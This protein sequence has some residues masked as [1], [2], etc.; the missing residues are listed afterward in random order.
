M[1][2]INWLKTLYSYLPGGP[3]A[4]RYTNNQGN[5]V[6]DSNL[7]DVNSAFYGPFL[8]GT[9]PNYNPIGNTISNLSAKVKNPPIGLA[10]GKMYISGATS[11]PYNNATPGV[12]DSSSQSL[13]G[14]DSGSGS[15]SGTDY[16][17]N[18]VEYPT[19][20]GFYYDLNNPQEK[21]SFYDRRLTDL[22]Y[23]RDEQIAA[24]DQQIA[25]LVGSSKN[26]ATNYFKQLENLGATKSSGDTS[27]IDAFTAASPNAFQS[28]EA[29]SY[30]MANKNYLKTVG[31]TAQQANEAVGAN[32]LANPNDVGQLDT[33]SQYGRQLADY[34]KGRNAVGTQYNDY[35]SGIEQQNNPATNPFRFDYQ[36]QGLKAPAAVDLSGANKFVDFKSIPAT[37]MPGST[38]TPSGNVPMGMTLDSYLGKTKLNQQDTDF[39]RKYLLGQA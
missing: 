30:D 22:K 39:L 28:S 17:P 37:A 27:R 8:P 26:Y 6:G 9:E 34:K 15:G 18:L 7:Y 35:L 25:D 14:G 29:N 19:G 32:Y 2:K 1:G 13:M 16:V 10:N 12:S 20:S 38:F 3:A 31:D 36:A 4:G 23:S 21:Q 24:I 5:L 11:G 33:N